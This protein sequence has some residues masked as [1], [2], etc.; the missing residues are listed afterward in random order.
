MPLSNLQPTV[1]PL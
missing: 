1:S